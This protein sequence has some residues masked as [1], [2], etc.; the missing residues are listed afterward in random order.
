M[1]DNS[2]RRPRII[3]H[4]STQPSQEYLSPNHRHTSQHR[5]VLVADVD[6]AGVAAEGADEDAEG[7]GDSNHTPL[8][9][10]RVDG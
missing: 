4:T 7:E 10:T 5:Q 8:P 2:P 6:A 3:H 9:H 1:W